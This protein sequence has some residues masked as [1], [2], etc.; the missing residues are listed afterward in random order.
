[1]DAHLLE[2]PD[3]LSTLLGRISVRGN[4]YARPIGCGDWLISPS[5]HAHASFHLVSRGSCWL[6][7]AS[8]SEPVKLDAGDVVFFPF[9]VP[10]QLSPGRDF[11]VGD[12]RLPDARLGEQTQLVCGLYRSQDRELERL[13]CG[14]PDVVVARAKSNKSSLASLIALLTEEAEAT[15][16]GT[17]LVLNALSDALLALLLREAIRQGHVAQGLLGGLNDPRLAPALSAMHAC[18]GEL[19]N[20]DTL[21]E[22]AAL[23]RSAFA[24]RFQRIMGASPAAYLAEVRMQEARALLRDNEVSVAQ[25]AERLGYATEAAFRRAFRRVVGATPG[26]VRNQ[27]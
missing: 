4:V 18:P 15:E 2:K 23:S 27:R 3:T 20:V 19:W 5:G 16:P 25:I 13:L 6:H 22:K 8:L 7:M 10:H 14:L 9:D 26:D 21:A 17:N 24:E 1:M 11:P 12:S